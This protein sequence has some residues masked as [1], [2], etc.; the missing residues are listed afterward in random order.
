[1]P[2]NQLIVVIS[3]KRKPQQF[4]KMKFYFHALTAIVCYW[5][6]GIF[7]QINPSDACAGIP[8]LSVELSC[9]QN[10][11]FLDGAYTNGGLVTPSCAFGSNRDDGWFSFEAT[12]EDITIEE[13]STDQSHLVAVY[14]TCGNA[15]TEIACDGALVNQLVEI[16]LTGLV[17]GQ[18]YYIQLQR[19]SGTGTANMNGTICLYET[20]T[21][22]SSET[23]EL[24]VTKYNEFNHLYWDYPNLEQLRF[25]KIEKSNNGI[26]YEEI[27]EIDISDEDTKVT[28]HFDDNDYNASNLFYRIKFIDLNSEYTYSN[29]VYVQRNVQQITIYPNPTSG[30]F[31]IVFP[32]INYENIYVDIVDLSG[33]IVHRMFFHELNQT[34]ILIDSLNELEVGIYLIHIYTNTGQL[35]YHEKLIKS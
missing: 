22:L 20:G 15:S 14:E 28:Q 23:S 12:A 2:I 17:V 13:V 1:M 5:N 34:E 6:F 26:F 35:I 21:L 29:V 24:F 7:A 31:T 3:A 10:T 25:I 27:N 32:E 11:Y 16:N 19:R 8:E 18:I 30:N 9:I 33:K 4:F